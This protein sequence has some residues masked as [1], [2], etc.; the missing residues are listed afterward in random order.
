MKKR[1]MS[2]RVK[3]KKAKDM[4]EVKVVRL[5]VY[6]E[7]DLQTT[8]AEIFVQDTEGNVLARGYEKKTKELNIPL[9]AAD[10]VK[11]LKPADGLELIILHPGNVTGNK[12]NNPQPYYHQGTLINIAQYMARRTNYC[13]KG[14]IVD[15]NVLDLPVRARIL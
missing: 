2:P 8:N 5:G 6:Y 3:R 11:N 9:L 4:E 1:I 13:R 7:V 10:I 12:S 15:E 14:F